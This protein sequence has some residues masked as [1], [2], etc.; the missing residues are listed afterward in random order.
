MNEIICKY[1]DSFRIASR[2]MLNAWLVRHD[3]YIACDVDRGYAL[4]TSSGN[5]ATLTDWFPTEEDLIVHVVS[6]DQVIVRNHT[7][8]VN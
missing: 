4:S 8:G 3:W 1:D 7:P 5:H 6:H 2:D